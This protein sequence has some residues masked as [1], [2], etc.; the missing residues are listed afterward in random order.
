VEVADQRAVDDAGAGEA[1]E[2]R[3]DALPLLVLV[4]RDRDGEEEVRPL[5]AGVVDA[6][7]RAAR[8]SAGSPRSPPASRSP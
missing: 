1:V 8:A 2:Q 7:A 3:G 5:D 4:L 6:A